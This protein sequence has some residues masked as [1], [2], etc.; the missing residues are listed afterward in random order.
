[1]W[2]GPARASGDRVVRQVR[3]WDT[4]DEAT[5]WSRAA[6]WEMGLLK[7]SDWGEGRWIECAGRT[8]D[9]P[10]PL[11]A[12]AFHGTHHRQSPG[13]D[14]RSRRVG[15]GQLQEPHDPAPDRGVVPQR[16][17]RH[18]AGAREGRLP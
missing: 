9:Q 2:H 10:L 12:R 16:R 3:A 5:P 8:P 15:H 4:H 6:S 11:F 14:D 1:M 7:R 17:G 13:S 18:P